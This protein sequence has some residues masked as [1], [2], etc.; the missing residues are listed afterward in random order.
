MVRI[1][2]L[3]S[4]WREPGRTIAPSAESTRC[5]GASSCVAAVTCGCLSRRTCS[6]AYVDSDDRPTI[7]GTRH[8]TN[9]IVLPSS[10]TC[11]RRFCFT[12]CEPP[13]KTGHTARPRTVHPQRAYKV[14]LR[15]A[16]CSEILLTNKSSAVAEMGDRGHSRH[17]PKR[18]GAAVSLSRELGPRLVQCGR[19]RGLLPYQAAS[20]PIQPFG[21]NRH[22]PKLGGDGCAF[23]LGVAGSTS[24]TMLRRSR[25]IP[26]P[27]GILIHA[28]VWPQ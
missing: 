4:K 18:E 13:R 5:A 27:S 11:S 10:R 2:E 3:T 12:P 16:Y 14:A 6:A 7:L 26:V 8:E 23:F 24:N 22:G 25:P 20:S 21:H 9:Q 1:I 19:G 28:A 15:P 17:G